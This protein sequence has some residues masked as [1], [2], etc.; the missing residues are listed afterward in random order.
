MTRT[1][2]ADGWH[3][4]CVRELQALAAQNKT[5]RVLV[6]KKSIDYTSGMIRMTM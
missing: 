5:Q 3:G 4:Q 6:P 1:D 2:V